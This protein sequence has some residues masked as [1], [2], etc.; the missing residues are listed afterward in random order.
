MTEEG[1]AEALR[2]N[3][4]PLRNAFSFFV[5]YARIDKFDPA[6][7]DEKRDNYLDQRIISE[8]QELIV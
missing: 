6:N 8:L 1:I 5:T 2:N 3:I 4:L 7:L